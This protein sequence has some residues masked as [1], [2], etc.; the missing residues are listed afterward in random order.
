[1][2]C[3]NRDRLLTAERFLVEIAAI[4]F[5]L[6]S[7]ELFWHPSLLLHFEDLGCSNPLTRSGR[8]S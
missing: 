2:Q 4:A 6:Q 5:A 7:D 8:V 1:M 3:G